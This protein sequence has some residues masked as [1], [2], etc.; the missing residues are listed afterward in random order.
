[1]LK[2]NGAPDL[3][4][5]EDN[6]LN[7]SV[8]N[9]GFSKEN[10]GYQMVKKMGWKESKGLGADQ[11]GRKEPIDAQIKNNKLGVGHR[12]TKYLFIDYD[13]VYRYMTVS[14][15]NKNKPLC[16]YDELGRLMTRKQ[17]KNLLKKATKIKKERELKQKEV[18]LRDMFRN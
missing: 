12:D 11:K 16:L 10:I 18:W 5:F 15:M 13:Y 8:P 17:I 9:Y 7:C 3:Q 14:E 2:V 6:D 1:M 4:F